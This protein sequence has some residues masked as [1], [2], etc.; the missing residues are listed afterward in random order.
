MKCLLVMAH[1]LPD[2]LAASLAS[3]V[4]DSL[5]A[6]GHEVE[7]EDLYKNAFAPALSA[8]ERSSY[9]TAAYAGAGVAAEIERLR[10]AE[11]IVLVFPTWWFGFPAM[12]KGWFDRVWAPGIA[13][14]HAQ[15]LGAITP[16]LTGLRRVLVVTTLG[17]PS[18]VDRWIMRRPVRRILKTAILGT[19]AAQCKMQMLS[20]YQSE[21]VTPKRVARFRQSITR[22]LASW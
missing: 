8:S 6:S 14:D 19:C 9:Y 2:S 22:A 13:Y 16:R 4:H 10:D 12:L 17:S 15:D 11:A 3:H 5:K 7:I 20:L 1:P 18:W 21:R